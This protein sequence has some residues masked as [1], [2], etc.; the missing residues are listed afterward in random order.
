MWLHLIA[1]RGLSRVVGWIAS[2]R[3]PAFIV[4]RAIRWF[5][6]KYGVDLTDV[7]E[8]IESFLTFNEFFT[9][10]L[11]PAARPICETPGALVSPADG[12]FTSHGPLVNGELW[13]IKGRTYGAAEFLGSERDAERYSQGLFATVYLSPRDYHR[14]HSPVSGRITGLRY[15][16]GLLYPVNH[17]SIDRID[18][19]FAVNERVVTFVETEA[20]GSVAIVMVGAT[21]VGSMQMSFQE[22]RTNIGG[23]RIEDVPVAEGARFNAGDEVGRF[24]LGSTVVLL[25]ERGDLSMVHGEDTPVR[26][27]EALMHAN[28]PR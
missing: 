2:A 1:R 3:L 23:T 13:Q 15:I 4:Q 12:L 24:H 11:L 8:P 16:P 21:N 5:I 25:T 6:G 10:T 22:Y 19:L 9:R 26:M 18:R 17:L 7:A 20:F 27:G 14:V 28:A